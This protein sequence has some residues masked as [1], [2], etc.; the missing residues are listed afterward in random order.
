MTEMYHRRLDDAL[1]RD[2]MRGF[3]GYGNPN[4]RVWLI[5]LEEGAG[6]DIQ[7][8]EA[9]LRTWALH[10]RQ[11][12]DARDYHIAFGLPECFQDPP[13]PGRTWT[14]LIRLL[15]G[16]KGDQFSRDQVLAIQRERWGRLNGAV[17]LPE[18]RPLPSQTTKHWGYSRWTDAPDL[19]TRASYRRA[20]TQ[21]RIASLRT[22]ISTF[23]PPVVIFY[24]KSEL[25][26]WEAIAGGKF[27]LIGPAEMGVAQY[28]GT[29]WFWV[30]HPGDYIPDSYF[31]VAGRQIGSI[32]D[33]SIFQSIA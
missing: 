17:C 7:E 2:F 32:A 10:R 6:E 12:E 26:R 20:W 1:L 13:K 19:A 22:L 14:R 16:A 3:F 33:R 27:E 31:E 24:G 15:L 5:G 25:R 9:R 21:P 23:K 30:R 18:L 11:F 4:A 28:Q 29:H 8:I